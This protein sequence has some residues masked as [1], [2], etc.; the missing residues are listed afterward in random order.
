MHAR[1]AAGFLA[2]TAVLAAVP[3]GVPA[4]V[5]TAATWTVSPGG[6]ATATATAGTITLTDTRTGAVGTCTSSKVTGTLKKGSGLS[7]QDIGTV[8]AAAFSSCATLGSVPLTVTPAGLP[9]RISFTS[10]HPKIGVVA[11]TVS[12]VKVVLT[13]TCDAVVNGTSGPADG[14]VSALY[15]D[16]IGQLTF[17]ASGTNLHYW[18]VNNCHQLIN[19]GDPVALTASYAVRPIQDITSP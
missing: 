16:R 17:L 6:T 9:W 14:V 18:H 13:G 1:L 12:G 3:G 15:N 7:G 10:Y 19:D 11:G 5:A 2:G 4:H 8:T